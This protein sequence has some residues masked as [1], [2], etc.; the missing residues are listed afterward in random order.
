MKKLRYSIIIPTFNKA[1]VLQ[2]C[3]EHLQKIEAPEHDYEIIVVDNGSV[4]NTIEIVKTAKLQNKKITYVFEGKP[5]LHMGRHTGCDSAS[6]EILCYIDEDSFVSTTWLKAIEDS[7]S[8]SMVMMVGGPCLPFYEEKPP[9][10]LEYFWMKNK[11][12]KILNQLSLIDYGTQKK[13]ISPT[14]IFGCNFS[15]RKDVFVTIGGSLPD[16]MPQNYEL[17]QGDG[18]T[19]VGIKIANLGYKAIYSPQV[20]VYH[21]VPKYRMT[22]NY[23]L[24]NASYKGIGRSYREIRTKYGLE[25]KA[26]QMMFNVIFIYF[27][28]VIRNIRNYLGMQ[29]WLLPIQ[30]PRYVAKIKRQVFNEMIKY[31]LF[32]QREV[33][34]NPKLLEWVIRRNYFGK[35]GE[36]P[37][38]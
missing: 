28:Q 27:A 16:A 20:M 24:A 36:L 13:E 23:F 5:G 11:N 21:F 10:W 6:G 17:F 34:N 1:M 30:Q 9:E 15:I 32:H 12:G 29:R 37:E 31:Y 22:V 18:E 25:T 26:N 3:L 38:L 33:Q 14:L 19:A 2:K 8:D 35:N 4:D 7:Y